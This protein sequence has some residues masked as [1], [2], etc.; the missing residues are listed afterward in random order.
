MQKRARLRTAKPSFAI[1]LHASFV[2]DLSP[3]R[4]PNS[5]VRFVPMALSG[6]KITVFYHRW[7]RFYA[8]CV[9][10]RKYETLVEHGFFSTPSQYEQYF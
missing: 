6:S 1:M 9:S 2:I 10:L 3:F 5:T 8:E 7:G 4:P